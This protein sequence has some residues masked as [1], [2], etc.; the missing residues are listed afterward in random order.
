MAGANVAVS[1]L[2]IWQLALPSAAKLLNKK[3]LIN[4]LPF[5]FG[6]ELFVAVVSTLSPLLL[7]KLNAAYLLRF[8][9]SLFN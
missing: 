6:V 4:L 3:R 8:S 9:A 2:G 7:G 1:I 5:H